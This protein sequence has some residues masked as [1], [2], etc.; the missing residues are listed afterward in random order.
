MVLNPSSGTLKQLQKHLYKCAMMGQLE[1]KMMFK[2]GLG[3]G[4]GFRATLCALWI[5][6]QG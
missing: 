1:N 5:H 2:S 3:K 4:L 6:F